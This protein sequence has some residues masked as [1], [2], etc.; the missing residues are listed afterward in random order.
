MPYENIDDLPP[1]IRNNLPRHALEIFPAAYNNEWSEY[2]DPL[3]RRGSATAEMFARKVAWSAVKKE[4]AKDPDLMRLTRQTN[5]YT[6]YGLPVE[7]TWC[8]LYR[9]SFTSS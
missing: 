9:M 1:A 6:A 7:Q 4:F 2:Q 8:L 3:R 5:Q